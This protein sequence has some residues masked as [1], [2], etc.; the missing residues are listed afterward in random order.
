M[1]CQTA[2]TSV[3]ITALPAATISYAGTPYC[4]TLVGAQP[5]TRHLAAAGAGTYSSTAGL[6]FVKHSYGADH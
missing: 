6:I 3:T 5:V 2:T 1:C 4:K